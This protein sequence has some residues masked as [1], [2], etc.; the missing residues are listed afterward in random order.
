MKRLG[1]PRSHRPSGAGVPSGPELRPGAGLVDSFD[2]AHRPPV[3]WAASHSGTAAH[4]ALPAVER[5]HWSERQI[6]PDCVD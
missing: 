2:G 5:D 6:W 1:A 4:E 3:T